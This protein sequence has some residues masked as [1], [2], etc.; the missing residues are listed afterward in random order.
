MYPQVQTLLRD[1]SKHYPQRTK[2]SDQYGPEM[3]PKP[4]D[5]DAPHLKITP[6][7][8]HETIQKT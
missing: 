7:N 6:H 2:N 8:K 1:I 4:F 3:T 5:A